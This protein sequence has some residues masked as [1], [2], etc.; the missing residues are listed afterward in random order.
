MANVTFEYNLINLQS[1]CKLWI[2]ENCLKQLSESSRTKIIS[3]LFK[4]IDKIN[5]NNGIYFYFNDVF[6]FVVFKYS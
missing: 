2:N 4:I 3:S 6:G 1:H 5:S